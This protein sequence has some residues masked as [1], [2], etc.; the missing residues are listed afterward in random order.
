MCAFPTASDGYY[1]PTFTIE[2]AVD[3]QLSLDLTWRPLT[4]LQ[5]STTTQLAVAEVQA[6]LCTTP[7][8]CGQ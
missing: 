3:W 6:I 5:T 1:Y 8:R 4:T 7:E 2:W